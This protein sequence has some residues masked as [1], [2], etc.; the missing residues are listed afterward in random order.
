MPAKALVPLGFLT[1]SPPLE[2]RHAL[3]SGGLALPA[4]TLLAGAMAE[5]G[6]PIVVVDGANSFDP[7]IIARYARRFGKHPREVLRRKNFLLTRTFTCHQLTVVLEERLAP[8]LDSEPAVL[9]LA[10]PLATF[11]DESVPF[12]ET[13]ALF[14]RTM[15]AIARLRERATLLVTQPPLLGA[16]NRKSFFP[17]LTEIADT[18]ALVERSEESG[19]VQFLRP[20][21]KMVFPEPGAGLRLIA[22]TTADPY[23]G[24]S[25]FG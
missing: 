11:M 2:C 5:A 20:D 14:R 25:L 3:L 12:R 15:R 8:L 7:Y 24:G 6:C 21:Q 1:G 13:G 18:L 16:K 17:A 9:L 23:G 4:G 22:K 19:R 10:G